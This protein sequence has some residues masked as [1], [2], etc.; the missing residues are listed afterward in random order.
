[1]KTMTLMLSLALV[2][3]P[4]TVAAQARV[5]AGAAATGQVAT[6]QE[7]SSRASAGGE[8]AVQATAEARLPVAPVH[9][10]IAEGRARGASEAQIDRAALAVH[11]RLRASA[12]AIR[13]E[14]RPTPSHAE[15]EA[16]AEAIAAGAAREDLERIAD[17]APSGRSL[18]AC[19]TALAQL[20][21]NGGDAGR[22][23]ADL[24]GRLQ[25]GASDDALM[26]LAARASGAAGIGGAAI[27]AAAGVTGTLGAGAG[28]VGVTG[29][30]IGS[31][32]AG[33][34]P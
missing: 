33:L 13:D 15:I 2:A 8:A 30:L 31:V 1:M 11:S 9:R 23:A 14:R 25:A 5:D 12:E 26:S 6:R 19:L 18:T 7:G 16:G 27:D 17:A 24:A 29:S 28:A 34:I 21:A 3:I 20:T 22:V 4:G 32:G 10:V